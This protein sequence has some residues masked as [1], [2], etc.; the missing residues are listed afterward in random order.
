MNKPLKDQSHNP[1]VTIGGWITGMGLIFLG[2]HCLFFP[3]V[4]EGYGVSPVDD[5]GFAYLLATGMRDLFIGIATIYL[6]I[7][8][9]AALPFYFFAMLIIPIADVLIVLRYGDSYINTWPHAAGIIALSL[10]SYLAFREARG[11]DKNED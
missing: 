7:R 6:L 1:I 5:K 3:N 11:H 9:R 2:L 8:F 10:I 4:A